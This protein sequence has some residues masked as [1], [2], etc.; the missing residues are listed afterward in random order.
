MVKKVKINLDL[1]K[2]LGLDCVPV[3][4]LNNCERELSYILAEGI[5]FLRLL[6][7]IISGRSI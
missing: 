6:E 3:V 7:G 1:P 2:M 5:L 4:V